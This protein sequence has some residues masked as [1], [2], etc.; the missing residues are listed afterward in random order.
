MS[1]RRMIVLLGILA[2]LV[3]GG[4]AA[5]L[6]EDIAKLTYVNRAERFAMDVPPGWQVREMSGPRPVIVTKPDGAE[7]RP[8]VTVGVIPDWG[9][10]PLEAFVRSSLPSVGGTEGFRLIDQGPTTAAGNQKAWTATFTTTAAGNEV[11]EKQMYLVAGGRAYIVT[12]AA[13]SAVFA[14]EEPNLDVCLRSF[15][16]GW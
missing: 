1:C 15:R 11:T 6:P 9:S 2:A 14:A 16:A 8:T 7:G 12:A 3:V 13:A 4:C 10:A 5:G